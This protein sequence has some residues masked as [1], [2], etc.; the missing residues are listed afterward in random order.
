MVP[1][2]LRVDWKGLY[3]KPLTFNNFSSFLMYSLIH[4]FITKGGSRGVDNEEYPGDKH[5]ELN[6][7]VWSSVVLYFLDGQLSN[8]VCD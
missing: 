2:H 5:T 3:V 1:L 8:N 7:T 6:D 4:A